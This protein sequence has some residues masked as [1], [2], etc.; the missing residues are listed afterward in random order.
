MILE[1]AMLQIKPGLAMQ[2]EQAYA[3]AQHIIS[4]MPGYVSHQLQRCL[5][6]PDKY[7]LLVNWQT[8]ED[9]TIGFRQSTQYQEWRRL[10][11][12]FY[13]PFPVVEHFE[14]VL[15]GA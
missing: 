6:V 3:R 14:S 7:V 1:V 11:H 13:D 12:D 9:H 15:Q 5:E 4:A 2:F 8:L 10:L